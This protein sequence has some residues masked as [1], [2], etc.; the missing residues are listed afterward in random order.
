MPW[1][2]QPPFLLSME[3]FKQIPVKGINALTRALSISTEI[4]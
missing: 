1:G 4:R 3:Y 2:G